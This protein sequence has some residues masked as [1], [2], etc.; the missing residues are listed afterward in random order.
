[1]RGPTMSELTRAELTAIALDPARSVVI[2]A[3]AGSGKTWLLV[4][5]IL[6]LLLAGASPSSILA[7]TF[8]R[9][10]AHEMRERLMDWLE[11]LAT[12]SDDEARKFLKLR[13][14]SE[15][16]IDAC[17][18]RA[19]AL[20]GE[21]AFATPAIA[22]STFHGWFQQLLS[23]APLGQ[24]VADATIADSESS[25]LEEAWQTFAESLNRA[26]DSAPAVALH[27]LFGEWG[28][29]NT[30]NL[31]WKFIR[32]RAEWRA[33]ARNTLGI[34]AEADDDAALIEAALARWQA[35]WQL[36][37]T[38]DPLADWQSRSEVLAAINSIIRAVSSTP[39]MSEPAIRWANNL[40]AANDIEEIHRREAELKKLFLTKDNTAL[41]NQSGWSDKAAVSNEF[42]LVCQSLLDLAAAKIDRRLYAYNRDALIA[43]TGLLA[44]YEKLKAE[45][46]MLDFAD[47][48]WRTFELLTQSEHAETIQYRLDTRYR[49][50]L[51]DE[52]QD[53]NPI[54]WQSLTAWLDASVAADHAPTVFMVGDP[55]QAIYR[56]RRTDARLF[57]IARDYFR[58]NFSATICDLNR[59]RR[60]APPVIDFVNAVFAAEPL[61][62][63]FQA[64]A[65]DHADLPGA[66]CV[67][68]AFAA[69]DKAQ[70]VAADTLRNPLDH[71]RVDA[72]ENRHAQEAQSL[73]A[74]VRAT[75][76]RVMV[77][78]KRG[79]EEIT[80]PA[81][82]GDIMVL[83]RRRAPLPAFEEALRAA[84]LPYTGAR[85][86][87]LMAA[88]EVRD[89]AALLTFLSTPDDDLS[90]AQVLKS[91]VCGLDE[92][93]L[94]AIRFH[95]Q[96]GAWWQR[97]QL[98]AQADDA[99]A[100]L[101]RAAELLADWMVRMDRVPVHDLLDRIYHDADVLAA[102]A[103]SVPPFMRAGVLANLNAFMALALEV[104]S[105]RYPSLTR[106][107]HEL[108][109]YSALPD[110]EAPDEGAA[111]ED[112][113]DAILEANGDADDAA[114]EINA[115]RLLT[116]HASKGLEAP[117]VW[118]IDAD[119]ASSRSDAHTIIADWP[120]NELAPR[121]FSFWANKELKGRHRDAILS[122]EAA[123]EAREQL[124]LLYV[125][126]TR[127]QQ[128][129]IISGS[130]GRKSAAARSWLDRAQDA[131][132]ARLRAFPGEF[133]GTA[134]PASAE[135][136]MAMPSSMEAADEGDE[137]SAMAIGQ[138][139]PPLQEDNAQRELGIA[140]HAL[141]E[142]IAPEN[143]GRGTGAIDGDSAAAQ[144]AR[145]ILQAPALQK[146]FQP[147]KFIAAHNELDIAV[148]LDGES[149]MQRIDRLVEFADEAWV[150]DYKTGAIDAAQHRPQIEAYCDALKTIYPAKPVRGAVIDGEG[151]L[152]VLR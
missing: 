139:L 29:F 31:L 135:V 47:L 66:V 4:S 133:A 25:L 85:P 15:T 88:L 92:Q 32:R 131:A 99:A 62:T 108:K 55:K 68:P 52:F 16:E 152:W 112:E 97:L 147:G 129:L 115:L 3:C 22:I 38:L 2:E 34:A 144:V 64:H 56:F 151:K 84:R 44:A 127:A 24:G 107:L 146:F 18:L 136:G 104:D 40:Q 137:A 94:M 106:F 10:A 21:V 36:D 102:Y 138:R 87:G 128:F 58:E 100:D 113:P 79:G 5:R 49:H 149:R 110:Q 78:V 41:K 120:A 28:L 122:E 77:K 142:N 119:E 63:G 76:G 150:L 82:Y 69:P 14:L 83:F 93:A 116:I 121:H 98:L 1:M 61:F 125:A 70:P 35:E 45:Q 42:N 30:R 86:G 48:E 8:T 13:A 72:A 103:A 39:K 140:I 96:P 19:R 57:E 53:T 71:A 60:N 23:A 95:D 80:R 111:R 132:V 9:K 89:M 101:K 118:L 126:S 141:L 50:I 145:R 130:A 134:L 6:R 73:V 33:Y 109:R 91:P 81:R 74:A 54:Q 114:L 43:G 17:L 75:V 67:L 46:R 11:L 123:Y 143:A 51:L 7:I 90:L 20:F 37:L 148:T 105:G 26:P 59:S 117:I 27:N 12:A 124:N 65:A